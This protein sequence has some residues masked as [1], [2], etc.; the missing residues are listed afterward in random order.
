MEFVTIIYATDILGKF[1]GLIIGLLVIFALASIFTFVTFLAEF[2]NKKYIKPLKIM[3]ILLTTCI[4]LF[5]VIPS[6]QTAYMMLGAYV[7]QK[8]IE[9]SIGQD[10][11]KLI[12]MKIKK[13]ISEETKRMTK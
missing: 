1:N 3:V 4:T 5:V 10:T 6:K 8:T 11:I 7:A 13:E 12:E 9:S 2:D